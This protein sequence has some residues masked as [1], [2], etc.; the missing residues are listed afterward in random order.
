MKTRAALFRG[1]GEPMDVAALDID[2]PR[3]D[4]VLVTMAAAGICGSDLH[5]V[6]GEWQ[7]PTPMVLGHEGAGVVEAVGEDVTTLSVGDRVIL[8]WAP[9]C[10]ECTSCRRGRP[11]ACSKLRAAIGAGTLVD[12]T[13]GLS[14]DGETVYRMTTVGAFAD[15]VLVP[16]RAAIKIPD[17]V[18]LEQAALLGCAALTGVGAVENAAGVEPG[19][20]AVVIGSGAVGQFVVQGLRIAGAATIVAVDPGE[21]RREMALTL[22]AT[23]A[24]APGE[25]AGV[26]E[27]MDEGFDYAFEAVGSAETSRTAFRA[28][29]NGGLA[30]LVGMGPPGQSLDVDPLEFITQEKTL[31]GSIYGS[32][33]PQRMTE[34]LLEYIADGR[35]LLEPMLG[36][37]FALDDINDAVDTALRGE[38]GRALVRYGTA[39]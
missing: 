33:D 14:R 7:R 13:T 36:E 28:L 23:Q 26:L 35:L 21:A 9:S 20:S 12:G 39:D 11:A 16:E 18:S 30:V 4:G 37:R 2:A 34:K 24:I 6:R 22:G 15:H 25:L 32:G 19:A 5:V 3:G 8:S 27:A 31:V 29:R 17:G 1:S 10:Q 38:G